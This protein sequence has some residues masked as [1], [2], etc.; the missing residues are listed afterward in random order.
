[1]AS[2]LLFVTEF[3]TKGGRKTCPDVLGGAPF[4]GA[5]EVAEAVDG[6]QTLLS[7]VALGHEL[8][9][10]NKWSLIKSGHRHGSLKSKVTVMKHR[11]SFL[12]KS[13]VEN[14]I[15]RG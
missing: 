1:M 11:K 2:E 3:R 8:P 5:G 12:I 6:K 4:L 9:S 14:P 10:R 15:C 13:S 7:G